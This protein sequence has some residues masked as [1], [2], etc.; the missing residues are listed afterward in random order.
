MEGESPSDGSN[1][2]IWTEIYVTVFVTHLNT[3]LLL[4]KVQGLAQRSC[5]KWFQI[6]FALLL[7]QQCPRVWWLVVRLSWRGVAL[8]LGRVLRCESRAVLGPRNPVTQLCFPDCPHP[9]SL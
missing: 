6:H 5:A 8:G 7:S 1:A 4:H 9:P 2:G 3:W